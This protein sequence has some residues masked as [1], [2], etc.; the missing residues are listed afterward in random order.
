MLL[1]ESFFNYYHSKHLSA[2]LSP[3]ESSR[4]PAMVAIT[5]DEGFLGALNNL[6]VE[7]AVG[8]ARENPGTHLV[9]LGRRGARKIRDFG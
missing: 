7:K 1:L 9:V 2:G 3:E 5:S 6:I 8:F 4:T